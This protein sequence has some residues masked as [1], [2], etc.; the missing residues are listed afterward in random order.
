MFIHS[1]VSGLWHYVILV[2]DINIPESCTPYVFRVKVGLG[3][4]QGTSTASGQGVVP[5]PIKWEQCMRNVT[6][7]SPFKIHRTVVS[8]SSHCAPF[9]VVQTG[10]YHHLLWTIPATHLLY[11]LSLSHPTH[12]EPKMDA[13]AS[14]KT[15][16][17]KS[18]KPIPEMI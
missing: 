12:F 2:V 8:R 17:L 4:M 9:P 10:L 18:W 6:K 13:V 3:K 1:S 7:I 14:F 15:F 5:N 11:N 16:A